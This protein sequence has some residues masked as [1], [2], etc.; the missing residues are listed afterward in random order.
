MNQNAGAGKAATQYAIRRELQFKILRRGKTAGNG[1]GWTVDIGSSE[2]TFETEQPFP[3]GAT[4]ELSI[5]WPV[6]LD[7][8]CPMQLLLRGRVVRVEGSLATCEVQKYEFRTRARFRAAAAATLA[9]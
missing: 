9:L 8:I 1:N 3:D 2:V 4:I 5:H 6:L 7:G